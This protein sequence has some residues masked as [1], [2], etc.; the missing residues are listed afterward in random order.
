MNLTKLFDAQKV[1]NNRIMEEHPEL[2]GQ[3]NVP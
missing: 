3:D 1:L 2:K